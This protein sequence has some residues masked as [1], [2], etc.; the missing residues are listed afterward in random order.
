MSDAITAAAVGAV[1]PTLAAFGAYVNA[2][3]ARRQTVQVATTSLTATVASL[4]QAV[5]RT[6]GGVGRVE[7][8]VAEL[9][10]RVARLEGRLDA[11]PAVPRRPGT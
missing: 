11:A 3:A 6:E 4:E 8:G 2:R 9:R 7:T 1:A 5:H 10:E